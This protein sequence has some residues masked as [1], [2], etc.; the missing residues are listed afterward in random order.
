MSTTKTHDQMR[1]ELVDKAVEDEDF[2]ARLVADPKAA[3]QDMFGFVVPDSISV[4][5][6]EESATAAHL[7]LPPAAKLNDVDLEAVV[8]GGWKYPLYRS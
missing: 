3:I 1:A 2:R 6:H 5:V 4:S 7:V 8:G